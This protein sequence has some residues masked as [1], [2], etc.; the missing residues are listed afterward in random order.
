MKLLRAIFN[1]RRPIP[2]EPFVERP[3]L[4]LSE[5]EIAN[6]MKPQG[7][8][9]IVTSTRYPPADRTLVDQLGDLFCQIREAY[10]PSV[11]EE[12]ELSEFM[13]K[14]DRNRM[15]SI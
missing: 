13:S 8:G 4:G 12:I 7:D 11:T 15:E 2:F 14:R 6:G 3:R 10:S 9:V 1:R 5:R